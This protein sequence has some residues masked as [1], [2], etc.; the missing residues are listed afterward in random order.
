M[1]ITKVHCG[2]AQSANQIMV[3]GASTKKKWKHDY[4][5]TNWYTCIN[6][7]ILIRSN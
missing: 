5:T 6:W 7:S 4:I 2:T 1:V 3:N